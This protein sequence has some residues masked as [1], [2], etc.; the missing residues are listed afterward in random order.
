MQNYCAKGWAASIS[1]V[2]RGCGKAPPSP[3]WAT[4]EAAVG[5]VYPLLL[6]FSIVS[7]WPNIENHFLSTVNHC[8]VQY[9][10]QMYNAKL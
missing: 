3:A 1:A 8:F 7:K 6:C 2:D 5:A 10:A 4:A 9:Y